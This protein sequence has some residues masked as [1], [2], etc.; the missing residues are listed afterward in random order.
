[1]D[2]ELDVSKLA[3]ADPD[4]QVIELCGIKILVDSED[5]QRILD[6][7]WS[8]QQRDSRLYFKTRVHENGTSRRIL[9]GRFLMSPK[10]DEVVCPK[11]NVHPCDYRKQSLMVCNNSVKTARTPRRHEHTSKYKG[12]W[13]NRYGQWSASIRPNGSSIF[14]GTFPTEEMAARAYNAAALHYF[15]E[16]AFLN[17]IDEKAS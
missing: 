5:V 13:R 14:L 17:F 3:E 15:G 1:M 6:Q 9:L 8:L 2:V 12:V 11:R 4:S 7:S 16:A 10:P